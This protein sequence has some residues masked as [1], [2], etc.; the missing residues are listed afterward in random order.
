MLAPGVPEE[1]AGA[2]T[3]RLALPQGSAR[4]PDRARGAGGAQGGAMNDWAM[5]A[6]VVACLAFSGWV[7]W[8]D[9]KEP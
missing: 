7:I 5:A 8:L 3:V 1:G 9:H 6:I 4:T 2:W